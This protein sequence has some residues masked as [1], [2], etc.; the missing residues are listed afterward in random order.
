MFGIIGESKLDSPAPP[1]L[2]KKKRVYAGTQTMHTLTISDQ[3]SIA[4][5]AKRAQSN[6]PI[7]DSFLFPSACPATYII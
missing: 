2:P 3:N 7:L 5:R 4:N 6:K 1:P